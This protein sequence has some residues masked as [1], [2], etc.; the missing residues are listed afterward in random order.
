MW[1]KNEQLDTHVQDRERFFYFRK[2]SVEL[3][4]PHELVRHAY[5]TR[6]FPVEWL[7]KIRK[8]IRFL[9]LDKMKLEEIVKN[10]E[11]SLIW[12]AESEGHLY[13]KEYSTLDFVNWL[14]ESYPGLTNWFTHL[15]MDTY[16][17]FFDKS[18]QSQNGRS[19]DGMCL[20]GIEVDKWS[21]NEKMAFV[22]LS[23]VRLNYI[24]INNYRGDPDINDQRSMDSL[25]VDLNSH[26]IS[27]EKSG[28]WKMSDTWVETCM[29]AERRSIGLLES[30]YSTRNVFGNIAGVV[31]YEY[32]NDDKRIP[33]A[34][35]K[36][37]GRLSLIELRSVESGGKVVYRKGIIS[38][39]SKGMQELMSDRMLEIAEERKETD[40]RGESV[41]GIDVR[42]LEEICKERGIL[43]GKSNMRFFQPGIRDN[44]N[45][46]PAWPHGMFTL[47]DNFLYL[48]ENGK[49]KTTPLF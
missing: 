27:I 11:R 31:F 32:D 26:K 24:F 12:S 15:N 44:D 30:G 16:F 46:M 33:V 22:D 4:L 38:S 49:I 10:F 13:D 3:K 6:V 28:N 17:K 40:E 9:K 45:K 25:K 35:L 41:L 42:D 8:Q 19:L 39:L 36:T 37:H 48:V 7:K 2:L 34:V 1:Y 47:I 43:F 23:R 14:K 5:D 29:K 18:L 20:D 21:G